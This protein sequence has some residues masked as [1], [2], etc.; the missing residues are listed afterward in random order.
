MSPIDAIQAKRER[1]NA[2]SSAKIDVFQHLAVDFF[3]GVG[4][5]VLSPN[6]TQGRGYD[7]IKHILTAPPYQLR[8][9]GAILTGL[10]LIMTF[11]VITRTQ[12][13]Y[14]FARVGFITLWTFFAVTFAYSFFDGATSP[15]GTAWGVAWAIRTIRLPS[16]NPFATRNHAVTA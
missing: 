8:T 5:W 6:R 13:P 9:V 3:V 7:P 12:W 16:L 4:W 15:L 1:L 11:S 10:A 14:D 2:Y